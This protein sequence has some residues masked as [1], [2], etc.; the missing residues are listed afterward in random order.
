MVLFRQAI[1]CLLDF[2]RCRTFA[3][4]QGLVWVFLGERTSRM[5]RL[6]TGDCQNAL[7]T[8]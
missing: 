7:V 3:H 1:V 8:A 5:E 6:N 4:T 2:G